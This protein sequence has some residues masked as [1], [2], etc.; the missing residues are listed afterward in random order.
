MNPKFVASTEPTNVIWENRHIKGVNFGA[1]VFTALLI[2]ALM[3]LITFG[4]IIFFKQTSI[5]YSSEFPVVDCSEILEEDNF[6]FNLK[7]AGYE[8]LDWKDPDV[9]STFNGALQCFCDDQ[10]TKKVSTGDKS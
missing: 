4:V 8:Y 10:Q 5:K 2:T 6:D 9:N 1:R 3:L 7:R